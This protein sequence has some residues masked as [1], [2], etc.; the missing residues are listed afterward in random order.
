RKRGEAV[1]LPEGVVARMQFSPYRVQL[2]GIKTSVVSRQAL[3]RE[4]VVA[5]RLVSLPAVP[6]PASTAIGPAPADTHGLN[7]ALECDVFAADLPAL[8][9]GRR[10]LVAVDAFPGAKPL[11]GIVMP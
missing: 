3:S 4:I 8:T 11:A 7:L 6:L 2:A 1:V 9:A 5:G 10:A